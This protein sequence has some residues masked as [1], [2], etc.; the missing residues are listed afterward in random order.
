MGDESP[1]KTEFYY[2]YYSKN[3]PEIIF[4]MIKSSFFLAAEL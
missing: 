1:F 3:I 2:V 4:L